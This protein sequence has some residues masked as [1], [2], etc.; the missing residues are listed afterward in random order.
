MRGGLCYTNQDPAS[1]NM[2]YILFKTYSPS[3]NTI[4]HIYSEF[5]GPSSNNAY[6]IRNQKSKDQT[7][8]P[9]HILTNIEG[10]NSNGIYHISSRTPTSINMYYIL[11]VGIRFHSGGREKE[12]ISSFWGAARRCD[13]LHRNALR[14]ES[15]SAYACLTKR[16]DL[17]CHC[18]DTGHWTLDTRPEPAQKCKPQTFGPQPS[19]LST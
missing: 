9:Y 15:A 4:Y 6:R 3:S 7:A 1:I 14:S 19:S 16:A 10:L 12:V 5:E 8:T 17:A 11:L 18:L 13:H 2:A